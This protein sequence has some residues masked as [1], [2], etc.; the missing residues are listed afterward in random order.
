VPGFSGDSQT[1]KTSTSGASYKEGSRSFLTY[2]AQPR[3]GYL[4]A[5]QCSQAATVDRRGISGY[6]GDDASPFNADTQPQLAGRLEPDP[7][8]WRI[9]A[10]E[11]KN[12]AFLCFFD[13]AAKNHQESSA[14]LFHLSLDEHLARMIEADDVDVELYYLPD[15]IRWVG[16]T[17]YWCHPPVKSG[18]VSCS[19]DPH[20]N[21]IF[22]I[23]PRWELCNRCFC[24]RREILAYSGSSGQPTCYCPLVGGEPSS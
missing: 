12:N 19:I 2:N 18:P 11:L 23:I 1:G 4:S 6:R 7:E 10:W 14:F 24:E 5:S 9:K 15:L 22:W 3:I 13:W 21:M 17:A 20:G 8:V 16:T